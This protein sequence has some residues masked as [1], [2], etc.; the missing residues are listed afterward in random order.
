MAKTS[1]LGYFLAVDVREPMRTITH[2]DHAIN[3]MKS[4]GDSIWRQRIGA[5]S[6]VLGLLL[7]AAA[8]FVYLRYASNPSS[9]HV[10]ERLRHAQALGLPWSVSFYGSLLLFI[11]SLFGLGWS[12][13]SGLLV[14]GGAFLCALM[15]LGA[16][17]GPFGCS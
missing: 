17:C 6:T 2:K 5:S 9:L 1:G 10:E 16:M 3:G 15:T 12:R 4:P 13:W 11:V 8:C 14:N 7:F